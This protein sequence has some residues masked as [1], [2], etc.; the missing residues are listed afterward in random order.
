MTK[1]NICRWLFALTA[2]GL[3]PDD[4]I[5]QVFDIGKRLWKTATLCVMVMVR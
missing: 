5:E 3:V 1:V 4:N 2:V